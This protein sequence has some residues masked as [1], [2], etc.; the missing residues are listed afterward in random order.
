MKR[1][2]S[3]I[4]VLLLLVAV[5]AAGCAGNQEA[6]D[7]GAA[8]ADTSLTDLQAKGTLVVGVD[9]AFP[10]MGFVD[11]KGEIIGFD[12]DLAK[13]VGEKLGVEV[14]IK[15]INWDSKEMELNNG[16][17]DVIWNGYTITAERIGKVE[18]SKPYLNNQQSIV[19]KVDSPV[20]TKAD[21]A[22]KI[23][24]A[25]VESAGLAAVNGD[26][27]FAGSLSEVREY[28]TYQDALM[29]LSVSDRIQAV[30]V[31]KILIGYVM[32]QQPDTYRILEESMGDEFYGIGCKQGSVALR[33]AI[34]VALDELMEDGTVEAISTQ[35][36]GSNI[37][38]R[39]VAKLTEADF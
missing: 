4:L 26:T 14:E 16:N 1:K 33:E 12:V 31:D 11:E 25:Q 21:L 32:S 18:F 30:V 7:Q 22:G 9:D 36:F 15:A 35:W 37:V 28:D 24:G 8:P 6:P 10:P 13:A 2:T 39:D 23:V 5:F 20:Q 38:L 19:V 3:L 34:D 17:I 27:E 29:D